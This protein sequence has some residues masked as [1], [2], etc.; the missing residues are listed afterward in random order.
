MSII[1]SLLGAVLFLVVHA[2][3]AEFFVN[4]MAA[5][6]SHP[7]GE[8]RCTNIDHRVLDLLD[9][10]AGSPMYY[11]GSH[12]ETPTTR[13]LRSREQE[14]QTPRREDKEQSPERKMQ[15]NYC[16]KT[17]LNP[18]QQLFCCMYSADYYS[19]CGSP[20]G[21]RR[22]TSDKTAADLNGDLLTL[23]RQAMELISD[24]CTYDFRKLAKELPE[25]LGK[26][27]K[28]LECKSFAV[29]AA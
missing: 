7:E 27:W 22:L 13:F 21:D 14:H 6:D 25:C 17:N 19:Y 24:K 16:Y 5:S 29:I 11:V 4:C 3:K 1:K 18:G 15:S 8:E 26:N 2:T 28:K 12:A 9:D 20:T 10:C 23:D